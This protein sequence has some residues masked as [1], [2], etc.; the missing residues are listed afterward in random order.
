MLSLLMAA[1]LLPLLSA[2]CRAVC[3]RSEALAEDIDWFDVTESPMAL[4]GLLPPDG[5]EDY[6]HRMPLEVAR[7]ASEDVVSMCRQTAGGRVRFRTDSPF[8][9]I[10]AEL[11]HNYQY[12]NLNHISAAG[13]GIYSGEA[14]E[15]YTGLAFGLPDNDTGGD[16]QV[17][18][19]GDARNVTV[20]MPLYG[21]VRAL[22]IGVKRGS[23]V[24]EAPAYRC[25]VPA[26][27]YGSSITQGG[28]AS[29]PG[30]SY[31]AILSRALDLDYI[32][33]GFSGS[34]RGE[35]CVAEY[36]AALDMSAFVLDY[37][38]NA[39]TPEHL[40]ATHYPFYETVR[41]K[42]P[43]IPIVMASRPVIRPTEEEKERI[44]IIRDSLER[45]RQNGDGNV[46]FVDGSRFMTGYAADCW[47]VDG[48]HP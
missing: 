2:A 28:C 17:P 22:Y 42:H 32:N 40:R 41:R 16:W 44:S 23:M 20:Y 11:W 3:Y 39:H 30:N 29:R 1:V 34:G 36:I 26:V 25:G 38:H 9:A 5:S 35:A 13:F 18:L 6:Y 10:H 45:A 46:Y 33:L 31:Q 27:F 7:A 43:D 21:G 12:S 47:S 14:E 37:D 15:S 19:P 4:Y 48:T 24:T 8:V